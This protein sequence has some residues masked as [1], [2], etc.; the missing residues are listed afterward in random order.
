[1][2]QR[3]GLAC[4]EQGGYLGLL[5]TPFPPLPFHLRDGKGDDVCSFGRGQAEEVH[6]LED[7]EESTYQAR[8]ETTD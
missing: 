5:R 1:M 7:L 8:T 4:S 3:T 2:R 6:L